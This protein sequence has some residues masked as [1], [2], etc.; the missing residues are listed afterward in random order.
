MSKVKI[1]VQRK[2]IQEKVE[3]FKNKFQLPKT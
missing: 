3:S 1:V 2:G